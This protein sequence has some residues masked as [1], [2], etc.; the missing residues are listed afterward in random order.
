MWQWLAYYY[1]YYLFIKCKNHSELLVLGLLTYI[2]HYSSVLLLSDDYL[3]RVYSVVVVV[4]VVV[5]SKMKTNA[6]NNDYT[7]GYIILY[8]H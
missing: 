5:V 2:P 6:C 4:V 8:L 7:A 1:Y 3:D